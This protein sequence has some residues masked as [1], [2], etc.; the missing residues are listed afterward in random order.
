LLAFDDDEIERITNTFPLSACGAAA[1]LCKSLPQG[2]KV[3]FLDFP[4]GIDVLG[5]NIRA[6]KRRP[7]DR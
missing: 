5:P 6:D 2:R 3:E 1:E 4:A 7:W